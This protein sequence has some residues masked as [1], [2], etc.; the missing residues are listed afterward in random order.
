MLLPEHI[1][2]NVAAA[3]PPTLMGFTVTEAV[4]EFSEEQAPLVTNA[5]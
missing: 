3:V 5:L 2:G 1:V 4:V